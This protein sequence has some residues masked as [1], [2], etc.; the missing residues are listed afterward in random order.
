VRLVGQRAAETGK[1]A[2]EIS[3][4]GRTLGFGAES[5]RQWVRQADTDEGR[6]RGD[7]ERGRTHP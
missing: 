5:V 6:S 2:G 1:E 3:P 7:L 4:V